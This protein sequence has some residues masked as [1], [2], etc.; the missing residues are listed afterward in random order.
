MI[1]GNSNVH[2]FKSAFSAI[3][4]EVVF[5]EACS[6]EKVLDNLTVRPSLLSLRLGG[7]VL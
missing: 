7:N 5:T 2:P 6:K 4:H 1:S 3:P